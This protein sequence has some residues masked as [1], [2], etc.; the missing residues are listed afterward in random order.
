M[1]AAE[2]LAGSFR[3]GAWRPR[4]P[5]RLPAACI[6][7]GVADPI[8]ALSRPFP[9]FC[10]LL[11]W[12]ALSN[13]THQLSQR[14]VFW[15]LEP[16]DL[17]GELEPPGGELCVSSSTQGGLGPRVWCKRK[18]AQVF[19]WKKQHKHQGI[20]YELGNASLRD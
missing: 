16:F 11:M 1:L 12:F 6:C 8:G 7:V 15:T 4:G 18:E 13:P 17:N 5:L 20:I 10:Q 9:P 19:A 14:G 3:P 2:G